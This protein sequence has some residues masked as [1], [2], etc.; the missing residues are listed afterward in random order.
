MV[1]NS[2]IKYS[3][4]YLF[5]LILLMMVNGRSF[6]GLSL[7][8][9]RLGEVVTGFSIILFLFIIFKFQYFKIYFGNLIYIYFALHIFFVLKII[10]EGINLISLYTFKSGVSIWYV[11]FLFFGFFIF[12]NF[13][14][15]KSF[16][17][18][19]YFGLG[20]QYIFNVLY[21]PEI[22]NNFFNEYSDKTQF[23]KGSEIAIFFIIVTFFTNK[24]SKRDIF[25][26]IFVIFSSLYIPL[27][28]FKSRS[29]GFAILLF[30]VFELYTYRNYFSKNIK[31]T[32]G[33]SFISIVLFTFS[34]HY[35]ID[36]PVEIEDTPSAVA[37]VFKHKY[38]VANTYDEE[39]PLFY[40]YENRIF[41]ADGNLNWRLQLWQDIYQNSE[42]INNT[43]FGYGFSSM[44]P[45]YNQKIYS[46]LDGLNENSHNFLINIFTRGG[47]IFLVLI[48]LFFIFLFKVDRN[49]QF[50]KVNF[51]VFTVPIFIIS[52]FDG[53]M[54]NPYFG[55]LFYFFLS[56]FYAGIKFE[57]E[58]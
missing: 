4:Q 50:N 51:I 9:F 34:S 20:I 44:H 23:L 54:E 36:N 25:L 1:K 7:L 19:G 8:G 15:S 18:F 35:L 40:I 38:I 56:S 37:Q 22:I 30:V 31:K 21:Y 32:I 48:F 57:V 45:I 3:V 16:F 46:G 53:S 29:G 49:K 58:N 14:I 33:I 13:K 55:I 6:L 27:M 11:S 41:S 43:I 39:V 42:S 17:I 10:F 24:F 5:I 47:L 28:F 12:K 52:M 2:L 26:D